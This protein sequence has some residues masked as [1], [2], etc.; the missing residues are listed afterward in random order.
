MNIGLIDGDF[1]PN[2]NNI[3]NLD[4]MQLAAYYK[5]NKNLVNV[6]RSED[7]IPFFA[8]VHYI[9]DYPVD[10]FP[11]FIQEPNVEYSG[12]AFS[13]NIYI[14]FKDDIRHI[15]PDTTLYKP[16]DNKKSEAYETF[17]YN[18]RATHLRLAD[19]PNFTT[20]RLHRYYDLPSST[21]LILHD[22][23]IFEI[24]NYQELLQS[25]YLPKY[26]L[27]PKYPILVNSFT[28]ILFLTQFKFNNS[29]SFIIYTI[30]ISLDELEQLTTRASRSFFEILRFR[31][32]PRQATETECPVIF[33]DILTKVLLLKPYPRAFYSLIN[34]VPNNWFFPLT[35]LHHYAHS[36]TKDSFLNFYFN[37]VSLSEY[38]KL[39]ALLKKYD[40]LELASR[41]PK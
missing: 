22:Y 30:P 23:N 40:L 35:L 25:V 4:L 39:E 16:P 9:K 18:M 15:A 13:E 33:K 8:R 20:L 3:F 29:D 2:K 36:P 31:V 21:N 37:Q 38:L 7:K 19:I 10:K 14:P 17:T 26:S 1:I 28:D 41:R 27:L 34:E 12:R 6:I 24:P 32:M 11:K 5:K